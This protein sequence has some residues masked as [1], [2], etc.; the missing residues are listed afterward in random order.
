MIRH[1][2]PPTPPEV[3]LEDIQKCAY[4]LWLE[5]GRPAGRD[6][7]FWDAARERLRHAAPITHPSVLASTRP[8]RSGQ[9]VRTAGQEARSYPDRNRL[10]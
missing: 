5:A 8:F 6:L 10:G 7:E 2:L 4:Y 3:P 1:P 9:N